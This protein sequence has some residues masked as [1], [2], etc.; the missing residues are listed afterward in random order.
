MQLL[1][2]DLL[3]ADA[4]LQTRKSMFILF[5]YMIHASVL[6]FQPNL[7]ILPFVSIFQLIP[8]YNEIFLSCLDFPSEKFMS[9]CRCVSPIRT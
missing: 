9:N 1:S 8:T 5:T 4:F 6:F 7:W 2:D 3:V